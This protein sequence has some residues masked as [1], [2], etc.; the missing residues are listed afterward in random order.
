MMDSGFH[1]CFFRS[2]FCDTTMGRMSHTVWETTPLGI[3]EIGLV[4][5]MLDDLVGMP[6]VHWRI[7]LLKVFCTCLSWGLDMEYWLDSCAGKP[8]RLPPKGSR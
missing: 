3:F 4:S 7:G 1:F 5:Q 2:R 8:C 6:V